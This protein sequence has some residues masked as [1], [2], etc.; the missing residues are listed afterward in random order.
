MKRTLLMFV[1]VLFASIER[2]HSRSLWRVSLGRRWSRPTRRRQRGTCKIILNA[3]ETQVNVSCTYSG[4]GS[5]LT[6]GHTHGAA[7]VGVNAGVLF[8]YNP[9]TGS[10][11]GTFSAGP[12]A[13]SPAQVAD[14]RAHRHYANLH[15]TGFP[16]GEIRGQI[17]QSNT[18]FDGD[19]DGRTDATA[20]RQSTNQFW[21]LRSNGGFTIR[22]HG[23]GTGD[24]WLNNTGDFDATDSA[25]LRCSSSAQRIS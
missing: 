22:T 19:G 6:A 5:N 18:V 2:R 12:F 4:L 3:A 7:A 8:N 17:K 21:T 14:M 15:T 24:I 13:V 9:P 11:S 25:T 16:G 20:F 1:F 23:T 10:T